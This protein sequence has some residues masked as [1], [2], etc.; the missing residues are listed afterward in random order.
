MSFTMC[1]TNAAVIPSLILQTGFGF[2]TG[3]PAVMLYGWILVA[4]FTTCIG[5]CL[6]EI[7]SVYPVSGGMYYWAG[8]LAKRKNAA[9]ASYITGCIYFTAYIGF[10]SSYS[11]GLA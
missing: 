7:C 1:F 5:A 9:F 10:A 2:Q 4:L 6:G 11:F 8:M 3:G